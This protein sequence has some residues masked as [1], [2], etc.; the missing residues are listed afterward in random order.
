MSSS[1]RSS[2]LQQTV[3]L[4]YFLRS[5]PF[6]VIFFSSPG[7]KVKTLSVHEQL[8]SVSHGTFKAIERNSTIVARTSSQNIID[9]FNCLFFSL[10]RH[11][12]YS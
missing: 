11:V 1:I 12:R 4:G 3:V 7:Y 8:L 10:E 6:I 5:C 2:S 9:T